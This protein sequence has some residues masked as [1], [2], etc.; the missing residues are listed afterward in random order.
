MPK[1]SSE[2]PDRQVT[3]DPKLEKRT[4]RV[5]KPE[6]KLRIVQEAN[7]CKHGE[8][9]ALLRREKLYSNQ[10]S[11]WGREYAENGIE[12]LSKSSPGPSP[13]KS[14]EQRE[15]EKLK[16]Q[17]ASLNNELAIANDCLTIQKTSCQFSIV[18]AMGKR[19]EPR[20]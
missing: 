4:R 20:S 5:F 14:A 15:T 10:L 3:P 6:Y 12:G 7:A 13:A 16:R 8:L 9:G 19:S 17:V 11:D 1:D 2:I 18:R